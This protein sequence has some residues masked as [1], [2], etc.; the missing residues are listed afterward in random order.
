[1]NED[2][3]SGT[4]W[5]SKPPAH[6]AKTTNNL[7]QTEHDETTYTIRYG[8]KSVSLNGTQLKQPIAHKKIKQNLDIKHTSNNKTET[9]LKM[10]TETHTH[11]S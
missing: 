4:A 10:K 3:T 7:K 11:H 2:T 6:T 9:K 8:T 1:M 5:N